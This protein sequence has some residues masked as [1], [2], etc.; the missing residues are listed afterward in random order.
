MDIRRKIVSSL[1]DDEPFDPVFEIDANRLRIKN[2][3]LEPARL[4]VF[5]VPVLD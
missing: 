4:S 1:F 3:T 2:I 5:L